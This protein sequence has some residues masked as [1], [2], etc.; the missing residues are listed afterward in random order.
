MTSIMA[1]SI[2][3]SEHS[4]RRSYSRASLRC[5]EIHALVR[6]MT[7]RRGRSLKP[8]TSSVRLTTTTSMPVFSLA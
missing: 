7:Q 3:A 5:A 1:R 8:F 6:S 4:T 2:I